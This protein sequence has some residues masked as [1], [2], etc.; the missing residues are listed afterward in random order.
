MIGL[1]KIVGYI[2]IYF[3]FGIALFTMLC[4]MFNVKFKFKSKYFEYEVESHLYDDD[5][6][7]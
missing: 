7:C 3:V 1:L 2:L 5:D 6:D 4:I